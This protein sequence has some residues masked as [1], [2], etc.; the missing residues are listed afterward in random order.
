MVAVQNSFLPGVIWVTFLVLTIILSE[1]LIEVF[2]L[3]PDL[4]RVKIDSKFDAKG[5]RWHVGG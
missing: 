5:G 4:S 3:V 2:C 1:I